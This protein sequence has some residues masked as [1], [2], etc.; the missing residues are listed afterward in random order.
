M[1][2]NKSIKIAERLLY[3]TIPPLPFPLKKLAMNPYSYD[4]KQGDKD[5]RKI[6]VPDNTTSPFPM[7]K[8]SP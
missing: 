1:I 4:P 7:T 6:A 5:S 2:Q 3:Q 8:T